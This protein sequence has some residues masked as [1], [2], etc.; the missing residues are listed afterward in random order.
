[1]S[2]KNITVV[3]KDPHS[4]SLFDAESGQY[5][6]VIYVTSGSIVGSPII[7]QKIVTVTSQ[8]NGMMYMTTY[9]LTTRSFVKKISIG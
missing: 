9:D 8:E 4:I 1:M 3:V 7:S 6:G 5:L 2:N